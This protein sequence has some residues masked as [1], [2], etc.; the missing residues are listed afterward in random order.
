[1]IFPFQEKRSIHKPAAP[2]GKRIA[3]IGTG[4]SGI[5]AM[6]TAIAEGFEVV[7]FESANDI[8][9]MLHALQ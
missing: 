3:V 9:G 2:N 7:A 4:L 6:K 1:L 8:G 5:Q